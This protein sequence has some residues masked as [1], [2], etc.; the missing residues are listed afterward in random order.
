MSEN[1]VPVGSKIEIR[2]PI[3]GE[4]VW[5]SEK[6]GFSRFANPSCRPSPWPVLVPDNPYGVHL[7]DVPIP[8]GNVGYRDLLCTVVAVREAK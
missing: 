3:H 1:C 7:K 6:E 4:W 2:Q 8:D 5:D